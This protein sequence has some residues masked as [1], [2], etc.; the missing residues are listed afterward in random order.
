MK[1]LY[2]S[3]EDSKEPQL[4]YQLSKIE[5]K[6]GEVITGF[7][8]EYFKIA[9]NFMNIGDETP[10]LRMKTDYPFTFENEYF[11]VIIAPRVESD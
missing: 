2:N 1:K 6:N 11:K 5:K 4:D 3:N 7:S 8:H 9:L 10:K